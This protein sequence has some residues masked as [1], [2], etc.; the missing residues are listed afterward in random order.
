MTEYKILSKKFFKKESVFLDNLNN[1]AR[2]GWKVVSVGYYEGHIS[3][4]VLERI[5]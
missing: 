2:N 3:K 4:A 5:K 1:D